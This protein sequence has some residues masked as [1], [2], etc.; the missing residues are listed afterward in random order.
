MKLPI[1]IAQKAVIWNK[2]KTKFLTLLRGI[3][4]PHGPGTWDLP[5]GDMDSG[6]DPIQSI[7]R[8]IEEETKLPIS[9]IKP[10]DVEAHESDNEWWVTIAY[11]AIA[12]HE[13]VVISWE[14]DEYRWVTKEEFLEL[15]SRKKIIRFVS[16][17]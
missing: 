16:N 11:E 6:E 3:T 9:S 5:G 1:G 12:G 4:A 17:I 13:K 10:F 2:N 14:H 15:P 7:L 8:E